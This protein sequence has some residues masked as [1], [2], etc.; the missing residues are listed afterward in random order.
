MTTRA[1]VDALKAAAEPTR[2]RIL[3]LLAAG[4]LTVKD[5]TRILG[6]SQPRTSRHLKL[7][8]EA[9]L[10]ERFR[11]GSWVYFHVSDRTEPGR[12]ARHFVRTVEERDPVISD[13]RARAE[14]LKR[15][16]EAAAQAYFREHAAEWD[17]IRALHV[18]EAE[19]ETAMRASLGLGPLKLLIDLGT[20]TG[21][22]LEL[23]SDRFERGLGVDV[24]QAMLAYARGKL[25]S[26]GICHADVRH[27][28]IYDLALTDGAADAIVMHQVLHVLANPAGAIAE[29]ARVLAPGGRLLIIDFAPHDLEFLRDRHAHER[30]GFPA[31]LVEQWLLAAGLR[32]L[33]ARDLAPAAVDSRP[34]KLT[35]S[36]WLAERAPE[37]ATAKSRTKPQAMEEAR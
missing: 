1:L 37:K 34:E 9:G 21:R 15:E 17:R 13:D 32:P 31:P 19:V 8:A 35:V 36:L 26:A 28:D 24:N 12:L 7:L 16:R 25:T 5:L 3:V 30:L 23:M 10:I 2:L 11:Q 4:E 18:A 33:G 20:G 29:A 27:G 14:A 22:I 6:Q